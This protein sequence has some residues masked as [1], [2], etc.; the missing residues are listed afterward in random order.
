MRKNFFK[1][2]HVPQELPSPLPSSGSI[3]K[4]TLV[5]LF[6]AAITTQNSGYPML[7]E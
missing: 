3:G 2:E 4:S 1:G 5:Y 7:A 6:D